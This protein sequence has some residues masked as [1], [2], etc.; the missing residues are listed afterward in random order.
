MFLNFFYFLRRFTWAEMP[1]KR[2]VVKIGINK[3]VYHCCFSLFPMNFVNLQIAFSCMAALKNNFDKYW[4]KLSWLSIFIASNFTDLVVS[5]S[6]LYIFDLCVI[7]FSLL[8][9][10]IIAWDLSGLAIT[11]LF[12][13]QSTADSDSFSSVRRRSFRF[14][15]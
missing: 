10:I 12:R 5:I 8:L 1:D 14:C 11:L 4:L 13:N 7:W 9:F 6:L 15:K 3:A 2:T